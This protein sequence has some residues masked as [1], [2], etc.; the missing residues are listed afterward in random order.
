MTIINI[1]AAKTHLSRLID[2][3]AAGKEVVIAKHGKPVARLLPLTPTQAK[4]PLGRLAGQLEIPAD[5]DEPLPE[6][7]LRGFTG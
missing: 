2:E 1:H 5:F 6:E 3:V 4:R 7:T